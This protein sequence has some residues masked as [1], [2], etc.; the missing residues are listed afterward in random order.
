[1]SLRIGIIGAGRAGRIHARSFSHHVERAA[2]VAMSDPS[3]EARAQVESEYGVTTYADYQQMLESGID[4]V[5]VVTP[6]KYHAQIVE[7]CASAGK[8]VLCEKPMAMDTTQCL[9]MIDAA[10]KAGVKLQIGFMRRFDSG[11]RRAKELID[12]GEI[13][14]VVSV[15]ALTHGPSIPKPWMYDISA[16]NGPLAEVSS[17]DIDAVRWLS[18]AEVQSVYAVAGNYRSPEALEEWPDFYD[19]V[20]LTAQLNNGALGLVDGAQ[21][22]RYG[23]DSQVEVLGTNGRID[24]GDLAA[25][26]VV[27]HS[28]DGRSTRDIVKTW[29]D[30]YRDA[31]V[32][33]ARSF[34]HC[35]LADNEPEVTGQDGLAAVQIV[36]AGN[37]SIID[38]NIQNL[39][40]EHATKLRRRTS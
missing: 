10:E 14:Q 13:G 18:G 23:Y 37:A 17:H 36:R 19:T 5:V 21:G 31:Y 25:N 34:V 16:S 2:L 40:F 8:H 3:P 26:R 15:K 30:L 28:S 6:T 29:G 33:E 11:F 1:M 39:N 27:L 38:S 32:D 4:A 22:V 24:V 35:I 7:N 12:A 9:R 20:L